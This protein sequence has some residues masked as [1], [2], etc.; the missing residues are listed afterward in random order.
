MCDLKAKHYLCFFTLVLSSQSF[1]LDI[2]S[3]YHEPKILHLQ[4]DQK[5]DIHFT[6]SNE[7]K[8][9]LKIFDDRDFLIKKITMQGSKGAQKISWDGKDMAGKIVPSEAYHYAIEAKGPAGETAEYD[10]TDITGGKTVRASNVAWDKD[11]SV[12]RYQLPKPARVIIRIGIQN[13]GPLMQSLLDWSP[14]DGGFNNEPWDGMD[15]SGVINLASHP[16]LDISV[17]AYSLSDNSIIVGSSNSNIQ[18]ISNMT[19][20]KEKRI[21]KQP[22][23]KK[24]YAHSQQTPETR[25]DLDIKLVL[26]NTPK[27]AKDGASVVKGFV[28]IRLEVS[29]KDQVRLLDRGF[30]PIFFL[31]GI[32][33]H[34]NE[35]G[36]LPVTWQWDTRKVKEGEHFITG[37]IRS[38]EGNFGS[39]TLKVYVKNK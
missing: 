16:K 11:K 5:A 24:M 2:A 29:E 1:A 9:T 32:Y 25:S 18:F 4:Q 26:A 15:A 21:V 12:I 34:E 23:K 10:S 28:P 27:E 13:R 38:Y 36:F 33:M 14:R 37:N 6:L 31:D 8:I 17:D 35:M 3:V 19:W 39:A 30:E 7:A 22:H 20:T